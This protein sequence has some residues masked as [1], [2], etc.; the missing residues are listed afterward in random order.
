MRE[1]VCVCQGMRVCVCANT[2][3][4]NVLCMLVGPPLIMPASGFCRLPCRPFIIDGIGYGILLCQM[5]VLVCRVK[6]KRQRRRAPS[7]ISRINNNIFECIASANTHT[8]H[9][10]IRTRRAALV[11]W[12]CY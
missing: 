8:M 9:A 11:A 10:R 5:D 2:R 7:S 12:S 6:Q 4:E 3:M 1:C